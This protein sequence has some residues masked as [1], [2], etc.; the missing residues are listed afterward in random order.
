ME[1]PTHGRLINEAAD[2]RRFPDDW[3]E[4]CALLNVM[5]PDAFASAVA[6]RCTW[7]F[8]DA[9]A[10]RFIE[11]VRGLCARAMERTLKT[12][13]KVPLARTGTAPSRTNPFESKLSRNSRSSTSGFAHSAPV[14]IRA[15]EHT[16]FIYWKKKIREPK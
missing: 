5:F 3:H 4:P 16:L 6:A 14:A 8:C 13:A 11:D 7:C 9:C 12:T 2:P 10:Q 1:L 15:N